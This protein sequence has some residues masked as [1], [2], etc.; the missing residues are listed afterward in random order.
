MRGT[1]A[2]SSFK[3]R[4]LAEGTA[5]NDLQ[6]PVGLIGGDQKAVDSLSSIYN[7]WLMKVNP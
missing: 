4:V 6:N 5:I 2:F 1:K 7:K 3:S